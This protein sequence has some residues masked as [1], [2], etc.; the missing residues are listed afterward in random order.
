MTALIPSFFNMDNSSSSALRY[1]TCD[2]DDEDDDDLGCVSFKEKEGQKNLVVRDS[3]QMTSKDF[4][5]PLLPPYLSL[6]CP[7]LIKIQRP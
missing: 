4:I 2:N 3:A 1:T 5:L 6:L 7:V